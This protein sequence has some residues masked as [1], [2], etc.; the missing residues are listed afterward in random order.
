MVRLMVHPG[1]MVAVVAALA[2]LAEQEAFPLHHPVL[3]A[4]AQPHL[5]LAAA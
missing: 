5:F 3:A 4:Q 2:L 1:P